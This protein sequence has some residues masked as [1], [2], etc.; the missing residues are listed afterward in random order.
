MSV[1]FTS[2]NVRYFRVK[3]S[4]ILSLNICRAAHNQERNRY[5]DVLCLDQT[6]VRLKARRN[7]VCAV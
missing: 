6:R 5:G 4:L 7:E 1:D 3:Q 2:H